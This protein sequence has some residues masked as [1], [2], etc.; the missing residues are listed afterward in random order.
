[1]QLITYSNEKLTLHY[2]KKHLSQILC[3][4]V[5]SLEMDASLLKSPLPSPASPVPTAFSASG[6][7]IH[8][9]SSSSVPSSSPSAMTSP[10]HHASQ[11]GRS[12]LNAAS[13]SHT[14]FPGQSSFPLQGTDSLFVGLLECHILPCWYSPSSCVMNH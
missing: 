12:Q 8:P 9:V 6:H 1:M 11:T 13:N 14:A 5:L 2:F 10:P 3:L 4:F 7:T